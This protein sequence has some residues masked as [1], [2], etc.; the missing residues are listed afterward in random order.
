MYNSVIVISN[1]KTDIMGSEFFLNFS[2]IHLMVPRKHSYDPYLQRRR[3]E[4]RTD[5]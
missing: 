2:V 4:H 3:L 5:D 1:N